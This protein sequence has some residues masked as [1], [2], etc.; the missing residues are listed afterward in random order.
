MLFDT[1]S[2]IA[3]VK[4]QLILHVLS[5]EQRAAGIVKKVANLNPTWYTIFHGNDFKSSKTLIG[6]CNQGMPLA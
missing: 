5:E 1:R 4:I 6:H 3:L 2:V